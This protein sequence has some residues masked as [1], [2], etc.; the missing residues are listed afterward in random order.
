LDILSEKDKK[1]IELSLQVE[2]QR[3]GYN[4]FLQ[5]LNDKDQFE[6]FLNF[7]SQ[8][9]S[10]ENLLFWRDVH[11]YQTT[12]PENS[13]Q[14]FDAICD[15]YIKPGSPGEINIHSNARAVIMQHTGEPTKTIFDETLKYVKTL[16]FEDSYRR[17]MLSSD[18]TKKI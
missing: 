11:A 6:N 9:N 12:F 13:R 5:I 3:L 8:E 1:N 18:F 4:G 10:T 14:Q 16:M 17:F 15:K 2:I 7:L